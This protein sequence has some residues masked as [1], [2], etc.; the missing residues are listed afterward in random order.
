MTV[1]SDYGASA[2]DLETLRRL[3]EARCKWV[4]FG[5]FTPSGAR[6]GEYSFLLFGQSRRAWVQ[7]PLTPSGRQRNG[8]GRWRFR[9]TP[10]DRS[11]DPWKYAGSVDEVVDWLCAKAG[12]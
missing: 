1:A 3:V 7:A 11:H 10:R 12:C 2:V 4:R 5:G 8:T 9:Q 6:V